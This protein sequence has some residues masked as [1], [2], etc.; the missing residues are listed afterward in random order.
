MAKV[1]STIPRAAK[2]MLSL[3][4]NPRHAPLRLLFAGMALLILM[5]LATNAAV[6]LSLRESE[7]LDQAGIRAD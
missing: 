3:A 1:I 6:I 5:L 4:T 7:L 2:P